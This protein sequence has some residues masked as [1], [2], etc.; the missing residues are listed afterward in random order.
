VKFTA[1]TLLPIALA[2]TGASCISPQATALLTF[3][4]PHVEGPYASSLTH[5]ET[6]E[7]AA[8]CWGRNDMRKPVYDIY[9][10]APD[11]GDVSSGRAMNSFDKVTGFKVRKKAGHWYIVPGS[12]Y[13]TE[14]IITS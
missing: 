10:T 8:L 4:R 7:I 5:A 9:L 12:I 11:E 3:P 2:L 1:T 14:V 6:L 13:E